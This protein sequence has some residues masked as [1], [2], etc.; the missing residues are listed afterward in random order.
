LSNTKVCPALIVSSKHVS[1]DIFIVPLTSKI[2]NLISGEFVLLNWQQSG[3][4]VPTAVKRDVYT[5]H[6]SLVIATIGTIT[7]PDTENL[8]QSLQSWLGL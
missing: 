7:A 4:N 2:Q 6:P 5:V 8:K 3:L 1:Q